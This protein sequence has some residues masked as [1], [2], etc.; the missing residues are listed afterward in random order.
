M[1]TSIDVK[2]IFDSSRLG[3][4]SSANILRFINRKIL[5]NL[6]ISTSQSE[7]GKYFE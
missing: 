7:S 6:V 5:P 4:I 1:V 2:F 3:L